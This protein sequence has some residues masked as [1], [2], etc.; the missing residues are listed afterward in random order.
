MDLHANDWTAMSKANDQVLADLFKVAEQEGSCLVSDDAAIRALLNRRVS[1]GSVVRP[2][3]SLFARP[4][5]W[6]ALRPDQQALHIVRGLQKLHPDM[7]FC[8]ETAGLVWGLPISYPRLVTIH[9]ATTLEKRR[10]SEGSIARH[11]VGD[12]VQVVDGI[13]VTPL[14]RT[15]FDCLRTSPFTEGLAIADRTLALSGSNRRAMHAAFREFGTHRLGINRAIGIMSYA[16]PRSESWLESAARALMITQGFALPDLQVELP[17]PDDP[18]R[19][20][21]VDYLWTLPGGSKVI[22]EADG[23]ST[24]NDTAFG[25]G[26]SAIQILA[27]EQHREAEL[28]L[29]GAPI[30]RISPEDVLKPQQFVDKLTRYGIPRSERVATEIKRLASV[31][32]QSKLTYTEVAVSQETIEGFLR[33]Q[34]LWNGAQLEER[35]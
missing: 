1:S 5:Y 35:A 11:I 28:T 24:Y 31:S 10:R 14:A 2:M 18:Q 26:R 12:D 30:L 23:I 4:E 27:D 17:R 7:V 20:Y 3:R 15:T 9:V 33:T 32:P 22:G 34:Q 25:L 19:T 8:H 6:H 13:T 21:R 29:Y 16:D